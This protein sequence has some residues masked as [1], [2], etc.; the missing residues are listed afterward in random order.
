MGSCFRP[1]SKYFILFS[2]PS[3]LLQYRNNFKYYKLLGSYFRISLKNWKFC[4]LSSKLLSPRFKT[5]NC[6]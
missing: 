4:S 2:F 1:S 3:K 6:N 5:K